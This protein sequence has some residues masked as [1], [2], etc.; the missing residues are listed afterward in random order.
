MHTSYFTYI[1][2][3]FIKCNHEK[4]SVLALETLLFNPLITTLEYLFYLL[5]F[6]FLVQTNLYRRFKTVT[7]GLS[8]F[9]NIALNVLYIYVLFYT[10]LCVHENAVRWV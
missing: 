8:S 10:C 7:S 5:L 6:N 1:I 4:Y 3:G 9:K 2:L